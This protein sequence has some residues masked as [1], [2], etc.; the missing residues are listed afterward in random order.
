[1][2]DDDDTPLIRYRDQFLS[3]EEI[4]Q[5]FKNLDKEQ[6]GYLSKAEIKL[7]LDGLNFHLS[8]KQLDNLFHHLKGGK[9]TTLISFE[10][11]THF[12][13]HR[14]V[15]LAE[16]F[17]EMDMN[18]DGVLESKE[19]KSSLAKI[20][21][22]ANKGEVKL[23]IEELDSNHDGKVEFG[24]FCRLFLLCHEADVENVFEIWRQCID[25]EIDKG[26][27]TYSMPGE[28]TIGW[29]ILLAGG[30][31]GAIS[32]TSTAPFDRLKVLLQAGGRIDGVKVTGIVSGT[33]I[34]KNQFLDLHSLILIIFRI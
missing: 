25:S 20:G 9:K 11:F 7:A 33:K 3:Q 32:R 5:V 15:L 1:M 28:R 10:Q 16:V 13:Q 30:V 23:L 27:T 4:I 22:S 24:E 29:K 34:T 17:C 21:I 2:G 14:Q 8:K 18:N 12:V 19:I 31:A 6:D 26:D